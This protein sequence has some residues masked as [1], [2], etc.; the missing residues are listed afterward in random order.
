M[1]TSYSFY[2]RVLICIAG[3]LAA[4]GCGSTT[5]P[6]TAESTSPE[7]AETAASEPGQTAA[8]E[9]TSEPSQSP[10]A[11]EPDQ[12]IF[13]SEP[14]NFSFLYDNAHTAYI[15]ETGAAVLA[16]NGDTS[17]DGLFVSVTPK[18]NM[19]EISQL[20]EEAMFDE[21]QK[22]QNAL[23]TKPAAH[24]ITADEHKLSGYIFSFSDTSG[25]TVDKTYYV[26]D[27][28]N[29]YIFY[30]TEVYADE[31]DYF[32]S[33]DALELAMR[34]LEFS[35]DAYGPA[36]AKITPYGGEAANPLVYVRTIDPDTIKKIIFTTYTEDG[37]QETAIVDRH[38]IAAAFEAIYAL[39]TIEP[40]D[41]D[42]LDDDLYIDI[43]TPSET[44]RLNFMGDIIVYENG[45]RY[46]IRGMNALRR[47]INSFF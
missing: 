38:D 24:E 40:T 10:E 32:V 41:M 19:P 43:E 22:Y 8:P 9:Q 29:F 16:I 25:E 11:E 12:H 26:E 3:C 31:T 36:D 21:E 2:C 17:L 39:E 47:I 42:V 4:A 30:K 23:I 34:T 1:K 27:R 5:A 18:E 13:V 14:L 37:R 6:E 46:T 20:L 33:Q 28:D 45:E 35:K 15:T 7:T 44:I